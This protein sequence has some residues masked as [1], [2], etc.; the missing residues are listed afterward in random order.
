MSAPA[1]KPGSARKKKRGKNIKETEEQKQMR[2]EIKLL[3]Q[4]EAKKKKAEQ[5]KA[6]IEVTS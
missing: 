1:S 2:L 5:L 3:R 4:E 6:A